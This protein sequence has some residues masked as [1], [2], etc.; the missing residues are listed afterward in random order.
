MKPTM[1]T[2]GIAALA[3][4]TPH[5]RGPGDS[6][7]ARSANVRLPQHLQHR[8]ANEAGEHGGAANAERDDR[9]DEMLQT[10]RAAGRQPGKPDCKDLNQYQ[11]ENKAWH[12]VAGDRRD[13]DGAVN[14]AVP[15]QSGID[16]GWNTDRQF[17]QE[18]RQGQHEGCRDTSQDKVKRRPASTH[19]AAEF[20]L[21]DWCEVVEI[22]RPEWLIETPL[23]AK[24]GHGLGRG[25]VPHD[26]AG[27]I[28]GKPE[29]DEGECDHQRDCQNGTQDTDSKEPKHQ[30]PTSLV[31]GLVWTA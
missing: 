11:A 28:S 19:R 7:G 15:V 20:A 3:G 23:T 12:R 16:T 30:I 1:V 14:G 25:V 5:N 22:L 4:R 9:Q 8:T 31:G 18:R 13:H 29:D 21:K 27:W 6:L 10:A 24:G 17:H 2:V 26:G